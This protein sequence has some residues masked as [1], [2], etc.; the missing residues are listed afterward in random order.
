MHL[1]PSMRLRD[2]FKNA[3]IKK[4]ECNLNRMK[5]EKQQQRSQNQQKLLDDK[6]DDDNNSSD[7]SKTGGFLVLCR[8]LLMVLSCCYCCFCCGVLG[9][10]IY[11]ATHILHFGAIMSNPFCLTE[12]SHTQ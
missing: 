2:S 7:I 3:Y 8:E 10:R 6:E 1:W 12:W 5:S 9:K 11:K 4:L